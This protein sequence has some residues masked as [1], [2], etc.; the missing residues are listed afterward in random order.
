MLG[1]L[2]ADESVVTSPKV[3]MTDWVNRRLYV[4]HAGRLTEFD[5]SG[6]FPEPLRSVAFHLESG[7]I[8]P[9]TAVVDSDLR[10]AWILDH[11]LNG[12]E[13][14]CHQ[15]A[16]IRLF[17]LETMKFRPQVWNLGLMVPSLFALGIARVAKDHRLYVAGNLGSPYIK[18]VSTNLVTPPVMPSILLSL[19]DANPGAQPVWKRPMTRECL[20]PMASSGVGVGLFP[21]KNGRAVFLACIRPEL[22][23]GAAIRSPGQSALLR[24]WVDPD[25][26][27][28]EALGFPVETYPVSGSYMSGQGLNGLAVFDPGAERMFVLSQSA[29]TPGAA[30]FDGRLSAWVGFIPAQSEYASALGVDAVSGHVLMR[31]DFENVVLADGRTT[32]V[33]QGKLISLRTL[34]AGPIAF[35][36]VTHFAY[37]VARNPAGRMRVA[38]FADRSAVTV[39]P[40]PPCWDCLTVDVPESAATTSGWAGAVGGFGARASLVGGWGGASEPVR[41]PMDNNSIVRP[42]VAG[43]GVSPG[44]RSLTAANVP[45]LD[46]RNVSVG[47]AA[48]AVAPDPLTENEWRSRRNTIVDTAGAAGGAGGQAVAAAEWPWPAKSCLDG[49]GTPTEPSPG[50]EEPG[51]AASSVRCDLEKMYGSAS[52]SV[53]RSAIDGLLVGSSEFSSSARRDAERGMLA[54]ASTT[55]RGI[56]ITAPGGAELSIGRVTATATVA[57]YGRPGT[58]RASWTR[59]LEDVVLRDGAGA[60]KFR[61]PKE[62][63]LES[64]AKAV[65]D[66]ASLKM[67]IILP[68]AD[69]QATRGGAFASVAK[70]EADYV[71]RL[72]MENESSEAVPGLEVMVFNDYAEKSR[73]HVQL[74]AVH[75]S[76]IYWVRPRTAGGIQPSPAPTPSGPTPILG[77]IPSVLGEHFERTDEVF[78]GPLPYR[79]LRT[80]LLLVRSPKQAFLVSLVFALFGAAGAS[81]W[82][83]RELV[84]LLSGGS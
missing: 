35:D 38:V 40:P 59:V 54:E 62:C 3:V 17:D 80:A 57:A 61:C 5:L 46:V 7:Q 52:A 75:L 28:V 63:S 84:R 36:P 73:L 74:A 82:R 23:G 6:S 56:H 13:T 2:P 9:Y 69:I 37:V 64:L 53:G 65:N 33:S 60:E 29:S 42:I 34:G 66:N 39:P 25:A 71:D 19:D 10:L 21:V 20:F 8:G 70:S 44:D 76:S 47:A 58:A 1:W 49:G 55:A 45:R 14:G 11:D 79:V 68:T 67:R 31:A 48:Q 12:E 51:G 78:D 15:C 32:P 72:T 41:R 30:V 83:R 16:L 26:D 24:I 22:Q 18:P 4:Q 81:V 50:G 43:A 27:D 77:R